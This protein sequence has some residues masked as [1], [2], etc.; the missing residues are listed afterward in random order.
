MKV[1]PSSNLVL[2]GAWNTAI[3]TPEWIIRHVPSLDG[4]AQVPIEI[5]LGNPH[6]FRFTVK[7]VVVQPASL[8]LDLIAQQESEETYEVIANIARAIVETLPHTPISAVGHNM[9]FELENAESIRSECSDDLDELQ[10]FYKNAAAGTAVNKMRAQHVIEYSDH[11]LN[12]SYVIS[13]IQRV[14]EFNYN[15]AIASP[16]DLSNSISKYKENM[17]QSKS[18]AVKL[19]DIKTQ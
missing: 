3:L 7:N 13:R 5:S 9:A 18:L 16:Q 14:I 6:R 4:D 17:L 12:V 15:Y 2:L 10:D 11:I 19:V 1:H 8:R